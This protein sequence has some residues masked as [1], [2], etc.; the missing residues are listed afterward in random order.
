MRFSSRRRSASSRSQGA[1]EVA[2]TSRCPACSASGRAS[3]RRPS[4]WMRNSDL[5]RREASCSADDPRWESSESISSKNRTE[6]TRARAVVKRALSSFSDSPRHFDVSVAELQLKNVM[7]SVHDATA[8]AIIVFPVPGGPN[9]STPFQGLR[10]PTKN[11]GR[12]SGSTTASLMAR[13]AP[14]RPPMSSKRTR[15]SATTMSRS[16]AVASSISSAPHPPEFMQPPIPGACAPGDIT[17]EKLPLP[18][19]GAWPPGP[20]PGGALPREG[21]ASGLSSLRCGPMRKRRM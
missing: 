11:S 6:G 8:F 5:K 1:F 15:R 21:A 16:M 7:F 2:R 12:I 14:S 18:R 19:R 9:S 13:L 3:L 4:M 17:L 20:R 10:R